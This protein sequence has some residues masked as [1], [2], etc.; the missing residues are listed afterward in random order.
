MSAKKGQTLSAEIYG[1]ILPV[2]EATRTREIRMRLTCPKPPSKAKK[3]HLPQQY[4][5]SPPTM[6][7]PF[8][9]KDRQKRKYKPPQ[10]SNI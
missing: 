9:Q 8:I 7:T 3:R 10:S 2:E 5:H 1:H 6:Q 4:Q